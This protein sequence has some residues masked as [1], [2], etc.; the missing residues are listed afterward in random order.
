MFDPPITTVRR[1]VSPVR[2]SHHRG[3]GRVGTRFFGS[4]KSGTEKTRV[5]TSG[6]ENEGAYEGLKTGFGGGKSGFGGCF[7]GTEIARG[8][9]GCF[10]G[11]EKTRVSTSGTP[12]F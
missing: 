9:E 7:G 6:L 12:F 3:D 10:G 1:E 11:T 2:P 8:F 4:S 5:S